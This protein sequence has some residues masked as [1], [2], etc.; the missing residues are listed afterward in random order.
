MSRPAI[1]LVFCGIFLSAAAQA[2]MPLQV[3][4][5][6]YHSPAATGDT[7]FYPPR[8]Y[9]D[10]SNPNNFDVTGV[11]FTNALPPGI[12]IVDH[13]GLTSSI[14]GQCLGAPQLNASNNGTSWSMTNGFI[15]AN[16]VCNGI[17]VYVS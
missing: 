8:Y 6:A 1:I 14:D 4:M 15:P 5:H 10:I 7:L 12:F 2:Q 13:S 9:V 17:W 3:T 16:G 11:S